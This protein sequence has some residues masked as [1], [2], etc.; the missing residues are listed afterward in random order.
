LKQANEAHEALLRHRRGL[1]TG[2]LLCVNLDT[3]VCDLVNAG[4]PWPLRMRDG[5]VE[6]VKLAVNLP[7]GVAAPT[8]FQVQEMRLRP[9]DR[10]ILLTDG[11]Q[12]RCAAAVDLPA[13]V[14]ATRA[15]HPREVVV[16]LTSAVR[17]ACSS[18]LRDDAT[19]LILDWHGA[20]DDAAPAAESGRARL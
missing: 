8:S 12:D 5:A 7:F 13:L 10:L 4:H 9:G 2:Q 16:A 15:L 6:E 1:A 14:H 17:D 19:V 3:G 18:C 20:R 11:M